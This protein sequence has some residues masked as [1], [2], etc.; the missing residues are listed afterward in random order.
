MA[1]SSRSG[2]RFFSL[3]SC[4]IGLRDRIVQDVRP[5]GRSTRL[6]L[7]KEA[8]RRGSRVHVGLVA[9]ETAHLAQASHLPIVG[10]NFNLLNLEVLSKSGW[11]SSYDGRTISDAGFG[12]FQARGREIEHTS[13]WES[14]VGHSK[15]SARSSREHAEAE[16]IFPS[17][18]PA[19]KAVPA[20]RFWV[21]STQGPNIIR[22]A[23]AVKRVPVLYPRSR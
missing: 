8:R 23:N 5:R 19:R 16:I 11:T 7:I 22:R 1:P 4:C 14:G 17:L 15:T 3:V 13:Q 10:R 18:S 9:N 2:S 12:M 6:K 20:A 21:D